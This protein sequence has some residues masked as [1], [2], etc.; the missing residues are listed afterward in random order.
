MKVVVWCGD[1]SQN[2]L[3]TFGSNAHDIVL[4]HVQ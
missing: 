2:V 3:A 1:M 4:R